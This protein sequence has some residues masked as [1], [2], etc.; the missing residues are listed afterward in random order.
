M[1]DEER[2]DL[3]GPAI[4]VVGSVLGGFKFYGPFETVDAAL[5]RWPTTLP[6]YLKLE[7]TIA[8]VENVDDLGKT[9]E[10]QDIQE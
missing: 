8:L 1:E 5:K 10:D 2:P 9:S 3:R 4:I 6:G 7:C